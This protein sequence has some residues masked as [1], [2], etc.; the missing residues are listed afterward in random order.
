MTCGELAA[1]GPYTLTTDVGTSS[2]T[3]FT[4][5]S[6]GVIINA[7]TTK[8]INGN[9]SN[10]GF[11]VTFSGQIVNNGTI[12]GDAVF[13]ENASSTGTVDGNVELIYPAPEPIG[14]TVLGVVS[15]HGYSFYPSDGLLAYWNLDESSGTRYDSTSNHVDLTPSNGGGTVT[16]SSGLIGQAAY[17][18]VSSY[19]LASDS[20][21]DPVQSMCGWV[22]LASS[23]GGYQ[24]FFD[25]GF[26]QVYGD[27]HL[28]VD[29]AHAEGSVINPNQWYFVCAVINGSNL[30]V[31][32]NGNVDIDISWPYG[33]SF[34]TSV[35]LGS[36]NFVSVPELLDE[37]A[38]WNRPLTSDEISKIYNSGQ[39]LSFSGGGGNGLLYFNAASDHNWS[40]LSNWWQDSGY[41]IPALHLPIGADIVNI[42]STVSSITDT[43]GSTTVKKITFTDSDFG[44][45]LTLNADAILTGSSTNSGTINGS[46]AF[47][48]TTVNIGTVN[49][50]ATFSENSSNTGTVN[51]N[52]KI[53]DSSVNIG[54]INGNADVY[55]PSPNP[56][57]G[58]VTGTVTYHNYPGTMYFND[59]TGGAD[60]NCDWGDLNNWWADDNFTD[61]PGN[62]PTE[63]DTVYV[64]TSVCQNSSGNASVKSATFTGSAVW[65]EWWNYMT[66]NATDFVSFQDNSYMQYGVTNTPVTYF[67]GNAYNYDGYPSSP[68]YISVWPSKVW[69]N[70]G[71]DGIWTNPANWLFGDVATTTDPIALTANIS[72][73]NNI[74]NDVYFAADGITLDGTNPNGGQFTINGSVYGANGNPNNQYGAIG[75]D[76]SLSNVIVTGNVSGGNGFSCYGQN[77]DKGGSVTLTNVT[78]NNVVGGNGGGICN[79]SWA[80]GYSGNGGSITITDS[81]INGSTIHAGDGGNAGTNYSYSSGGDGGGVS[82][83]STG[84]LDISGKTISAGA[85]GTG[86]TNDGYSN[87]KNGSLSLTYTGLVTNSSTILSA[88]SNFI[89]NGVSGGA[90]TGGVFNPQI[91]YFDDQAPGADN[92]G[93]WGDANNWWNDAAATVPAGALPMPYDQTVVLSD[94]SQNSAGTASVSS[95]TFTGTSTNSIGIDSNSI[96]FNDSSSNN[97]DGHY[98]LPGTF[99]SGLVGYWKL[100]EASGNIVDE[101]GNGNTA[102]VH[103][104]V[105]Y[106]VAGPNGT[107]NAMRFSGSNGYAEIQNV[108]LNKF[109]FSTWIKRGQ[110]SGGYENIILSVNNGGWGV[111]I[112]PDNTLFFTN[113][114]NSNVVS[115][116]RINDTNWHHVVVTFDSDSGNACFYF[117]GA[118][119]SGGCKNYGTLFNSS[120]GTYTINSRGNY[121]FSGIDESFSGMGIWN[122]V[123]SDSEI[124][125]IYKAQNKSNNSGDLVGYWKL[126]ETAPGT[127]PGGTDFLDS[128]GNGN[129]G[130]AN[131]SIAFGVAGNSSGLKGAGLN[132]SNSYIDVGNPDSLKL[133]HFTAIAWVKTN[134]T[135]QGGF[136]F[137]HALVGNSG[138][139]LNLSNGGMQFDDAWVSTVLSNSNNVL[140]NN[141]HQVGIYR[142][143]N[144]NVGIILDGQIVSSGNYGNTFGFNGDLNIG[145]RDGLNDPY[146]PPFNGSIDQVAIWDR[147]LSSSE[148]LKVYQQGVMSLSQSAA[149]VTF[150]GDYSNDNGTTTGSLIRL[151]TTFASTTRNFITEGGRSDWTIIA[152]GAVVNIMGATYDLTTDIFKALIDPVTHLMGSFIFSGDHVVPQIVI[153]PSIVP[154]V[155]G[156]NTTRTLKWH[157]SIDWDTSST[158]IYSYNSDFSNATTVN[159]SNN[160]TALP[161]PTG[162]DANHPRT[163]YLRGTDAHGDVTEKSLT[164]YYDATSPIDTDCSVP[165]DEA[166][167]YYLTANTTANCTFAV[168][169]AELRGASST[170][171]TPFY[172]NGNVIGNGHNITLRNISV[173][174]TIDSSGVG[175]GSSGGSISLYFVTTSSNIKSNG[176]SNTNGNGGNGGSITVATSTTADIITNGGS[177]TINGGNGGAIS[178]FNIKGGLLVAEGGIAIGCDGS[179]GNGG[180]IHTVNSTFVAKQN[181]GGSG[182]CAS[183]SNGGNSG[184]AGD[185]TDVNLPPAYTPPPVS[186]GAD[187]PGSFAAPVKGNWALTPGTNNLPLINPLNPLYLKPLPVFSPDVA[188]NPGQ[189]VLGNPLQGLLSPGSLNFKNAIPVSF[190]LPIQSFFDQMVKAPIF[191]VSASGTPVRISTSIDSKKNVTEVVR[192]NAKSLLKISFSSISK[193]KVTG[194]FNGK[195]VEFSS[196][197]NEFSLTLTAPTIPGTYTLTTSA[198][199]I[200]LTIIVLPP[201][202]PT[203]SPP[204]SPPNTETPS[205]WSKV[206]NIWHKFF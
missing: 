16:S 135:N 53:Q 11:P 105:A 133:Q 39:G 41:T 121:Q 86:D 175:N 1:P 55:A 46:V 205:I 111:G 67:L 154:Y 100:D 117:D 106:S 51:G 148:I 87:G 176:Q 198:S 127:A 108:D 43:N 85:G 99:N 95:V 160:D 52:A 147:G 77:P 140:D 91:F 29:Y 138:W 201:V 110:L 165:L 166:R 183:G 40:N 131:G 114:G 185:T 32:L 28:A 9:T 146:S 107:N 158:C 69:T 142:D 75:N 164:Y 18:P 17:V 124:S 13:T 150:K 163:L 23:N 24:R 132:G 3:C 130:V 82:I 116:D 101:S 156:D 15:Y 83:T 37:F 200:P 195:T 96:T 129:N 33:N 20:R 63:F 22:N 193:G 60:Y 181:S 47:A 68:L 78:T 48:S 155:N 8:N 12:T 159:C 173:T 167:P 45:G 137:S 71:G 10:V 6:G 89:L 123:L 118:A 74:T 151:F 152:Q 54:T 102:Q 21:L 120:G 90:F 50:G 189:T 94:V 7:S 27:H 93:D 76:V 174:G 34:G 199:P 59:Q 88:L 128:S 168:N 136:V 115:T 65:D 42:D 14:G 145:A 170:S 30:K 172:L 38:V 171:A 58:T 186:S 144:N 44:V 113:V 162:Q 182:G 64:T 80:W 194:T 192:V 187:N 190:G 204:E 196:R 126:D 73:P 169:G 70:A 157:P 35:Q 197:G 61:H 62:I 98:N 103:G 149:K 180:P 57:G 4:V 139:G 81:T 79:Y 36:D 19:L 179:G 84:T 191:F 184:S 72:L 2:Q 122:R 153:S 134:S 177:G 202:T 141:W 25:G 26:I 97:W 104:D 203:V 56:V 66:L 143:S 49:G 178:T 92:N 206:T 31:W 119:D 112:N 5:T 161:R 125:Q 109:T 188:A